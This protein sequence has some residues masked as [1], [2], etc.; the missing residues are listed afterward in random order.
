[1]PPQQSLLELQPSPKNG[2][3]P[4]NPALLQKPEQQSLFCVQGLVCPLFAPSGVQ[5]PPFWQVCTPEQQVA[6]L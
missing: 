2:M 4:Q 6:L 5:Q 3:Q 1:M